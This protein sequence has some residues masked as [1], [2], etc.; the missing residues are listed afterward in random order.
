MKRSITLAIALAAAA[1]PAAAQ[2]I[3]ASRGLGVPVPPVDARARALG[4]VGVALRSLNPSLVNPADVADYRYRGVAASL[5]STDRAIEFDGAAAGAGANRFPL[6]RIIHPVGER[7][8][9]TAGYGAFLDQSWSAFADRTEVIGGDTVQVRDAIDASGGIAQLQAG[10]AFA[11]ISALAIGV[12][13]GL[14]TGG[15]DRNIA[16]TFPDTSMNGIGAFN[17]RLSW[18]ERAPFA[19]AGFRWDL[20]SVLRIGGSVTWA[21]TLHADSTGGP[22]RDFEIDLPLQFAGG[23][24]ALLAPRLLAAVSGRWSGW[25][26]AAADPAAA[27]TW[28]VGGGIEW[29]GPS[30]GNRTLP[31]RAGYHYGQYP[32]RIDGATPAERTVA[33]GAG[34]HL[35]PTE[36]GPLAALDAALERGRRDVD[37]SSL[38]EDFWRFTVSLSVFGR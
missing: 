18:A 5:Q 37:G 35:A 33:V 31:L 9:F 2:S 36:A 14:Y 30:I 21:G 23:A 38:A 34:L 16:R 10:V 12:A 27:D 20:A 22:A 32:F 25:S 28:E 13:A 1:P 11:P 29:E 6:L 19:T 15:F 8:T 3:F 24:S 7:F 4:G 17:S 26:R